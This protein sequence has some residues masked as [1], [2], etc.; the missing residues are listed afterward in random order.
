MNVDAL[1][2]ARCRQ[3]ERESGVHVSP[4]ARGLLADLLKAVLDDPHPSWD[5]SPQERRLFVIGFL[6]NGLD[7]FLARM[8]ADLPQHR[9]E[10]TTYD[11]IHFVAE[12]LASLCPFNKPGDQPVAGDAI[13]VYR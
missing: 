3:F 9:S 6:T 12:H 2:N 1:V 11:L 4:S 13:Q 5:A 7:P 8:R 10:F